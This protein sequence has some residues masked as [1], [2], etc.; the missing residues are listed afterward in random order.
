MKI[1][2]AF[3]HLFLGVSPLHNNSDL[4][5]TPRAKVDKIYKKKKNTPSKTQ[6]S[7]IPNPQ[8][9]AA[10][11]STFLQSSLPITISETDTTSR[12]VILV[13]NHLRAKI[14]HQHSF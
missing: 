5:D 8:E 12:G 7:F 2:K 11:A 1:A 9:E 4:K 13:K 3:T 6:T 14:I 10:M